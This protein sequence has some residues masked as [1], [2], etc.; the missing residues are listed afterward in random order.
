MKKHNGVSITLAFTLA[1]VLITLGIIGVVA[2][3][4]IPTLL[5]AT[6]DL[7]FKVA[8]KKEFSVLSQATELMKKDNGGDLI[9]LFTDVNAMRDN[10]MNYLKV[11]K[12]CDYDAAGNCFP[13]NVT[14]LNGT[15]DTFATPAGFILS[16]GT[17]VALA[18][19]VSSDCTN[20]A[21][22]HDPTGGWGGAPTESCGSI[23]IDINGSKQP[24]KVSKD[25]FQAVVLKDRL[26]PMSDTIYPGIDCFT[27]LATNCGYGYSQEYLYK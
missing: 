5:N 19:W 16:D 6:Q 7:Q 17:S 24:N 12:Y 10:Y 4:T 3:M 11:V 2:A 13:V 26:V 15:T 27:T 8:W 23:F 14:L 1:E 25:I 20:T 21:Y 22:G 9:G 18:A